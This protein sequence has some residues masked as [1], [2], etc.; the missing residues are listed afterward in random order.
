MRVVVTILMKSKG[1]SRVDVLVG[2][3]HARAQG[4]LA[5]HQRL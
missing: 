1:A 4:H 5:L 3:N 2:D